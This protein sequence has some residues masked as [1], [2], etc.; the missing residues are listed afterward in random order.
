MVIDALDGVVAIGV[1][2][3]SP[4]LQWQLLPLLQWRLCHSQASIVIKLML[5]PLYQWGRHCHQCAGVFA[6]VELG[7]LPSL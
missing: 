6:V 5:L 3:S 2:A 7:L 4:S 1:Q